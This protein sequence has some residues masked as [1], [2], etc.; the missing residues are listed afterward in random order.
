MDTA[1][2]LDEGD[3]AQI[4]SGLSPIAQ[5]FNETSNGHGRLAAFAFMLFNLLCAPCFAA[6]GAIRREM[7]SAKWT[8]FAI[9]YQCI[10]AYAVALV[11]YQLGLLFA[12]AG[13]TL[14]T[15]VAL[16]VLAFMLYML[17]RRNRYDENHL[18]RNV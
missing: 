9:G 3:D 4:E 5:G 11:V 7:N 13:F 15:T 2:L 10:F 1:T 16:V 12:G 17:L 8:W 18:S 14:A 6:I